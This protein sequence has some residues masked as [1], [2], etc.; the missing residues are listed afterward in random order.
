MKLILRKYYPLMWTPSKKG[1][2]TIWLGE[3]VE[4]AF[5]IGKPRLR[6]LGL[7]LLHCVLDK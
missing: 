4:Q 7:Q 2:R 5:P 1:K 6:L 3:V